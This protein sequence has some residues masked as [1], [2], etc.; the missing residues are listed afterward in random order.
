MKIGVLSDSHDNLPRIE[1]AIKFFNKQK[2]NFLLHAGDFVAPFTIPK[3]KAVSCDWRGVFGNNDGEKAGLSGAS[4]GKIQ[5]GPLRLKLQ[6]QNLVLVH[7][8][9]SIDPA[10]EGASCII[11]GHTHKPEVSKKGRQILVNP[12]ESGGWLSGNSTVAIV[13]LDSLSA[14]IFKI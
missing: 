8:L 1:K 14:R 7:D 10:R 4:G 12:G 9:K 3:I 11:F 13:D 6:D 5:E 2:I